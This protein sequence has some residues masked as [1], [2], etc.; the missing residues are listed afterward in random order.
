[1]KITY[2]GQSAIEISTEG[3]SFIIDPFI[4]GNPSAT[5]KVE[6][7]KVDAVLL[8]HAHMDHILDAAPIAKANNAP[9]CR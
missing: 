8:T 4:S 3:K 7:V 9:S 5:T 1:M 2:H 6:E